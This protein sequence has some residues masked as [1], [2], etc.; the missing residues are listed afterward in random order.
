MNLFGARPKPKKR[1][2]VV[3]FQST[4][5]GSRLGGAVQAGGG[6]QPGAHPEYENIKPGLSNPFED[7]Y[8]HFFAPKKKAVK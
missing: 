1:P 7:L 3:G 2:D 6:I 5:L 4:D 8:K